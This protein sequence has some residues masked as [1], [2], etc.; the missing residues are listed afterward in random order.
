MY[1]LIIYLIPQIA[2][3]GANHGYPVM[4]KDSFGFRQPNG[5]LGLGTLYGLMVYCYGKLEVTY[6]FIIKLLNHII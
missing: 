2:L 6:S 4:E 1:I 3:N 5:N